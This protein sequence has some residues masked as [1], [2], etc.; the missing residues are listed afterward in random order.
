MM[1]V[2]D[3]ETQNHNIAEHFIGPCVSRADVG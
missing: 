2:R 1:N 3:F